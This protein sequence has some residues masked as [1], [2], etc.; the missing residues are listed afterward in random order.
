MQTI[1]PYRTPIIQATKLKAKNL[2]NIFSIKECSFYV[3]TYCVIDHSASVLLKSNFTCI[4]WLQCGHFWDKI[5]P[6]Y[7]APLRV[8]LHFMP[9]I[10]RDKFRVKIGYSKKGWND[11]LIVVRKDI[12]ITLYYR[13]HFK[14]FRDIFNSLNA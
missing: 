2:R 1:I 6:Q 3:C 11:Y 14:T 9:R 7:P 12:R 13:F 5:I 10:V 8:W 4:R